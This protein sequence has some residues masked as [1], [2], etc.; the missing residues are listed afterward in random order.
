MDA[1]YVALDL[2][3]QVSASRMPSNF[4]AARPDEPLR[5][6]FRRPDVRVSSR[7]SVPRDIGETYEYSTWAWVCWGHT[8]ALKAG[9]SYETSVQSGGRVL[10]PSA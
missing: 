6:L 1:D 10:L 7:L 3:T 5:R 9:L 2:A 4:A 8:L